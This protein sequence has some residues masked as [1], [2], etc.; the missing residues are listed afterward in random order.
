MVPKILLN[1]PL[2]Y[3]NINDKKFQKRIN[4]NILTNESF[5]ISNLENT[6]PN[7]IFYGLSNSYRTRI[8]QKKRVPIPQKLNESKEE[9]NK[10]NSLTLK[11]SLNKKGFGNRV[12][13]FKSFKNSDRKSVV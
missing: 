4:T 9:F 2:N 10:N 13:N 8:Y 3:S 7:Y 12:K 6:N 5:T 11:K 1:I